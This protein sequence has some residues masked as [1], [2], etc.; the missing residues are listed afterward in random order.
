MNLPC[1]SVR[2][3]ASMRSDLDQFRAQPAVNGRRQFSEYQR[4]RWRMY[5]G[6]VPEW[7]Q[8]L[9]LNPPDTAAEARVRWEFLKVKELA[10]SADV[11]SFMALECIR[12]KRP[13]TADK[14]VGTD[15]QITVMLSGCAAL[16]CRR[17]R[18]STL[19]TTAAP[20]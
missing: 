17:L 20:T 4:T 9:S 8:A 2:I 19:G 5:R 12:I 7:A 13:A 1:C 14:F 18:I 3:T 11:L 15:M 16:D 10:T 6:T